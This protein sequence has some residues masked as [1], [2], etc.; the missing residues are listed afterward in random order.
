[1]SEGGHVNDRHVTDELEFE[2]ATLVRADRD[3]AEGE[4][5]IARQFTLINQL[6]GDGHDTAKAEQMLLLLEQTLTTWIAHRELIRERIGYL[7]RQLG[8][9][10]PGG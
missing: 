6:R 9:Q 5:R 8:G 1:L 10:E 7:E 4:A 3:I 2:R